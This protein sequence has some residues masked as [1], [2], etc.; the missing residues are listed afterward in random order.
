MGGVVEEQLWE[1]WPIHVVDAGPDRN[2]V[3]DPL[4]SSGVV[5]GSFVRLASCNDLP[6]CIKIVDGHGGEHDRDCGDSPH[7]FALRALWMLHLLHDL[8]LTFRLSVPYGG[9]G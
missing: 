5:R 9:K 1:I 3:L 6:A 2:M 8:R 4:H 7:P